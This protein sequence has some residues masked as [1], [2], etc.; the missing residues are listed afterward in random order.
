MVSQTFKTAA[1]AQE[2]GEVLLA[3]AEI[4]STELS[5]PL[6][7][8]NN[9]EDITIPT[10]VLDE[11]GDPVLD[12]FGEVVYDES[13]GF[14]YLAFPFEI[15]LPDMN[16]DAP[17]RGTITICNV[18]QQIVQAIRSVTTPLV[19]CLS[20]VLASTPIITEDGP[21]DFKLENIVADVFNITG[22]LILNSYYDEPYP[23]DRFTPGQ[24]AG[25]F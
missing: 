1:Y 20:Q 17:P 22:D 8:V 2:T 4:T 24:Y 18:D 10:A 21:Y 3:I 14:E 23:G 16:A 15:K 7:F 12:E 19:I 25:L 11:L 13:G 5:E 9:N 6:R